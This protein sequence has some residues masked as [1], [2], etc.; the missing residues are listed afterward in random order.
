MEEE[1]VVE[2]LQ[3]YRRDRRILLDFLLS[4]S[5]I[6]KVIM[7]PGAVTLDDVDLDQV[8]VDY[9]LNCAK[10]G[11][12]LELSDAIRDYH[13]NAGLPQM[14]NNG[15]IGEFFLVTDPEASGSPPKRAPPSIPVSTLPHV[16]AP[17]PIVSTE[18]VSRSDSFDST[19]V[20]ELSVDSTNVQELSVDSTN[21]QELTVDDIDD[22]EDDD[23]AEEVDSIRVS[24]RNP[25]DAAELVLKLPS[26]DTGVTDD[27]LRETAYEVLLACAGASGG[28][29]VPSKE[30][31]KDKRSRLMRKLGRSKSENIVTQSQHATGLVGL[32]ETMRVQMEISEAMDIRTRQGLL[33]ALV[34][35]VGKRLD[36]LLIPLELLGCISRSEFSDKKAYIRWQ[37][38]QLKMLEEGLINHPVVGFGESG[39]K[40]NELRILLAKIEES[41]FLPSSTGEL[42]RTDCL[43]SLREIGIPLAERPA[44]GDLTGE[45]CHWADG[46]HLNVRLYEKL[47]LSVFDMLDEGKLTEEVEEILELLKSTWRVLG[48]TETIHYTCYAWLLFRQYII[49]SERGML[50]HAIEQLKKIPSWELRGPQERLHLKS[51][52]S[53]VE[54]EEFSFLRSFLSP[55]QKWADK[56]LGDYH[57]HFAEGSMVMENI[58]LVAMLTRR[59][60]LEDFELATKSTSDTDRDQI[61]SYISLSIK[62]AFAR[63][64]QSVEKSETMD[65]HPLAILAEET[66]KL[67]KKDSTIFTPVLSQRHPQAAVVSASLLHKLYGI[68]L[69]PF[70]DGAEH[71]TEDVVSVFPAAD[72]LEQYMVSVIISV[73][74]EGSA[75]I[76]CRKLTQYQVLS[77]SG[78]LVMRWLNAQLGRILGWIERALQQE[79]WEP[80]S[81]QQRHGNSIVEVYRIVEET[82]DQFFALKVPMR[83]SELNSLFRG[84]DNAFQVYA[85]HV[86]GML[87][88]KEDL[89]PP[90]PVLTRHK[91]EVGLKAFVKKELFD[92]KQADERS[93][94]EVN[95]LTTS[96]LCVQTNSLHYAVSQLN[97]LEDSIWERWTRKTPHENFL[98]KSIDEKSKS[99]AP[100]DMFNGSRTDINAA[101]DRICEYTGTKII[102]CD[103]RGPFIENLY[104]TNVSVS[105]LEALIEP[106]DVELNR[107]CDIIVEPLR[108]RIV[109]SLLQASLDGLLRVILDGGPSRL[110]SP[111]DAKLLEED[112]EVLKEFFISGGDGLPRGVVENQVTRIRDVIK[113]HGYETREIIDDLK[114][115]SSMGTRGGKGKLGADTNTLLRILCHRGDSEASLFLKKQ[116]RIPKSSA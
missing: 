26:F 115:T 73:C 94:S 40:A 88:A 61:E 69:K 29:I 2:L 52:H 86:I 78:T 13:D 90:V 41:E 8:S 15:A 45:I 28:L 60:L 3:R 76:Y 109:T 47:L 10:K 44:R 49:T 37:K 103:L 96:T 20:Q 89:I 107:L 17:S 116:F 4:G 77:V 85:N 22:F 9:V 18:N 113:L 79:H 84:I 55:I 108:D 14:N 32:L 66:K 56:R 97:K 11:G 105:R 98:R 106:L 5:L 57:L 43:R 23:D 67:L 30:K 12:M 19:H 36:T 93:S 75:E 101:I 54:G 114:S 63:I 99:F 112:L 25:N 74:G 104:K 48:I 71:L 72:S 34:G 39:R 31:K 102:F 21:V 51:L 70:L 110:F 91:R 68:K 27:D 1:S 82:V 111:S 65:G 50:Q 33:N 38:R 92:S 95:Q 100:K 83:S 64:L 58:L 81:P 24:R 46:Y 42:Q 6:K 80:I 7:P 87:A 53:K 59:L 62:N 16:F 35:K